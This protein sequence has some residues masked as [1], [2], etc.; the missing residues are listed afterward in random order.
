[1]KKLTKKSTRKPVRRNPEGFDSKLKDFR[2]W[3]ENNNYDVD[4]DVFEREC[5]DLLTTAWRDIKA[6]YTKPP[7]YLLGKGLTTL[8]LAIVLKNKDSSFLR[9]WCFDDDDYLR[10]P[11]LPG[12]KE[13]IAPLHQDFDF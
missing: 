5:D 4:H 10:R 8:D 9:S 1:M 13:Y 3:V 12:C 2:E 6:R 7:R 11:S